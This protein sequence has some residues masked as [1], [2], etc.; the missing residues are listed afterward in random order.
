MVKRIGRSAQ[1]LLRKRAWVSAFVQ[2][3]IVLACL[4][5]AWLLRFEFTIPEKSLLFHASAVLVLIRLVVI[6]QFR[7][8]HGWWSFTD[9]NDAVEVLKATV[10]GSA[11]FFLTFRYLLHET[12]FPISV[13]LLEFVFTTTALCSVRVLSRLMAEAITKSSE[14]QRVL[15]VGA[16]FGA[17][18][19]VRELKQAGELEIVGCV[20]DDRSKH[21]IKLLGVPVLGSVDDLPALVVQHG[22][23]Q[24]LI[25]VPSATAKQMRRFVEICE[26]T[27]VHFRTVPGLHDLISGVT[28][29]QQIRPVK[30]E[31]LLSREAVRMDVGVV[32][33]QIAGRGVMVTGAAGSI[34]S[35]LCRQILN[36]GPAELICVD[37]NENGTF[38]L[39]QELSRHA[40]AARVRYVVADIG[41]GD[42][43]QQVFAEHSVD[44]VF[45]AAAYKHVPVMENNVAAAI[46]NNVF[47]LLTL[48]RVAESVGCGHF[49]MI[50]SD[51]AVNPTSVMGCTKRVCELILASRPSKMRCLSVRFGNVLGSNGSVIPVF[52][53]QLRKGL[54]LTITHPDI[55]RYFMTINE[56]VSL[57]LQAASVGQARDIM[58]LDMG[59]PVSILELARTVIR[60]SGKTPGEVQ[61][62]FTGLR[63]G[64][65]LYEELF[66]DHENAV[67]SPCPK[68]N[69]T[70][71][72]VQGWSSLQVQLDELR[73][74]MAHGDAEELRLH[75]SKIVPQYSNQLS[76]G[77]MADSRSTAQAAAIS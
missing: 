49:V 76:T 25:A 40:N 51:K 74:A 71:S 60:L 54:P 14:V 16:G 43:M 38:F 73:V 62:K 61:I 42:R 58:V 46:R 9:V 65:K 77:I 66:Y 69:R 21:T 4:H 36:Y 59:E 12:S 17:Q 41:N 45:H 15:V 26:A 27:G 37:H 72:A 13:Y 47:A 20:D 11:A 70:R 10:T 68:I 33:E 3:A 67:E 50:S 7:L 31:D 44:I 24:I 56:A 29:A 32:R 34:G 64:E 55:T 2:A 63:K 75:L 5:F 35:E 23:H 22:V 53:E 48:L 39:E 19:I 18:M 8:L 1:S 30:P 6:R 57:V 52:E 28:P